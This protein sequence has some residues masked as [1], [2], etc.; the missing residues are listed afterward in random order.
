M[1]N[2]LAQESSLYLRQHA[3]NPVDWYPWGT[4]ALAA[5]KERDVPLLV[6]VGYSA[7]HWCHVMAHESFE[8]DYIAGLMNRNFVC[9]KVDREERPDVDSVLM[10][11]V[12]M[13]T[14]HG[15][16]PL[17][18]FCFADGRPFFGGT[19]FPSTD[20]GHGLIPWP[21][22]LMRVA[23]Y[24]KKDRSALE[25]NADGILKNLVHQQS[26]H[27]LSGEDGARALENQDL[28]NAGQ[29]L[30][31][32]YDAAHGG[33]GQAPKFPPSMTLDFLLTLRHSK[34]V[35]ADKAFAGKIDSAVKGTLDAMARGG[36]FDQFGGGFA[37]YSVDGEWTIP[38][39]EKMLYDNA[40]LLDVYAKGY[41]FYGDPLFKAVCEETVGWLLREMTAPGGGFYAALDADSEGVEGKYYVW[42]P[43][44]VASILGEADARR[45]CTAY[46]ITGAGNFEEGTTNPTLRTASFEERQALA[47]LREKLLE[48]RQKRIPPGKD[49]KQIL[50]WNGLM[51]RGLATASSVFG[52]RDWLE[53]ALRAA[54]FFWEKMRT[55]EGK[56]ASV[57]YDQEAAANGQS[58]ARFAGNLDDHLFFAEGLLALASTATWAAPERAADMRE[59]AF[60]LVDAVWQHFRDAREAGCFFTADDAEQTLP[61][62]KEW[63]DNATPA[64]NSCWLRLMADAWALTGEERYRNELAE[65]RPA[66]G[67]LA[68]RYPTGLGHVLSGFA[69]DALGTAVLKLGQ[70]ADANAL[71]AALANK[72]WRKVHWQ[73]SEEIQ[74]YQLCIGTQCLP[75]VSTAEEVAAFL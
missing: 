36:L 4:E 68:T 8:D 14:G 27:A 13:L 51:L 11:A 45:F 22:L 37:R 32:A 2:R 71:Q 56:L 72:P 49:T 69:N 64:G 52:R 55:G 30:L 58:G 35:Q 62:R 18:V 19:Y 50:A 23:D 7:C 41:T 70:D 21:Q 24:W 5:A 38:H 46:G 63:F 17:N 1:P 48:E 40:L 29:T 25:E 66:Y 61:R 54:D 74:G 59:R 20:K 73:R 3:E 44:E 6:S 28:M 67:T 42:R 57:Y 65:M 16:W 34:A 26:P 43:A 33:F 15:G 60:V 31:Q 10:Q 39:F 75:P 9:V 47:S 12:T 53:T